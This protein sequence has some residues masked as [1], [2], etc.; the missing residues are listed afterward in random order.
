M[1]MSETPK[2]NFLKDFQNLERKAQIVNSSLRILETQTPEF[3]FWAKF[4]F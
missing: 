3:K 2:F 4:I 1:L